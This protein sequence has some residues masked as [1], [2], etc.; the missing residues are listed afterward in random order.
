MLDLYDKNYKALKKEIKEAKRWKDLPYSWI[1]RINIVKLSYYQKPY[2][3][4]RQTF[5][6]PM[7]FFTE[8]EEKNLKIHT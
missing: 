3:E 2:T 8:I 5:Q 6:T 4:S 1:S 7:T